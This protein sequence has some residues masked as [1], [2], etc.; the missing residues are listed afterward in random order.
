MPSGA[1]TTWGVTGEM[2]TPFHWKGGFWF[3]TFRGAMRAD[4]ISSHTQAKH[5]QTPQTA[6]LI[7]DLD[8]PTRHKA[9]VVNRVEGTDGKLKSFFG[10]A[11]RRYLRVAMAW[12]SATTSWALPMGER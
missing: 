3:A 5:A 8:Q 4:L 6:V 12:A 2:A 1:E 9:K 7:L 10:A 11:P